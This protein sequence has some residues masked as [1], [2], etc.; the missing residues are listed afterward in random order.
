MVSEDV[1]T[2]V[3]RKDGELVEATKAVRHFCDVYSLVFHI[4]DFPWFGVFPITLI[5]FLVFT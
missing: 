1:L 2:F 5:V 3:V 4:I